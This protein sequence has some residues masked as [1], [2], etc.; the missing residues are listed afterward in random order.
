METVFKEHRLAINYKT[1]DEIHIQPFGD[2]HRDTTTCDVERWRWFLKSAK[3]MPDN[4]LFVGMGDFHDFASAKEAKILKNS[5]IHDQTKDM[6]DEIVIRNNRKFAQ[7]IS[8]MRGRL[9]GML[10]GNHNWVFRNGKTATEDLCERLGC[11]YLGWLSHVT[12][13]VEMYSEI[14]KSRGNHC[15]I[16]LILCHG[17]AGGKLLGTSITQVTDLARIFPVADIYIMGHDHQR[18]AWPA[19]ILIPGTNK[20]LIKQKRQMFCRSGCFKKGYVEGISGYE[21][22]RLLR[23]NDLGVVTLSISFHRDVKETDRIITDIKA[24]V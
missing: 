12:I 2:V 20:S 15:N 17:K 3:E 7:E 13:D 6:L 18:G 23:P 22:G 1:G 9:I 24:I 16:Y 4:T 21:I 5:D 14:G 10:D 11:P 8:F 19:S